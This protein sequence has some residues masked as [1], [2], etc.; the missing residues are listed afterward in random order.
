[1]PTCYR[2]PGRET[3]I[4]C[5]R[6]DKPICPDCMRDAAVGFQCPD[7]VK[8]AARTSRQNRAL[9]GGRRSADPRLT[10]LVLI[11]INVAVWLAVIA[12]GWKNS[13]LIARLALVPKGTCES[14]SSGGYYPTAAGERLCMLG[15]GGDGHWVPG[16]ADGAVWQL[17]TSQFLHVEIWHIAG[18][19]L[20]LWVLGPQ[21]EAILGRT[22]FL[23]LYLLSGLAGSV[24]VLWLSGSGGLTLGASGAI[25]GL[26]GAYAVIAHKVRADLR[27]IATL[28]VVNLF[29]TFAI[30]NI[31]WQGHLGGIVG[32]AIIAAV[33]AYAPRTR[34]TQ[35]QA[36]G[37]AGFFIVLVALIALR[38]AAL[39]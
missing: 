33:I 7:C 5:Q 3:W 24:A 16:V 13:D 30:P 29:I 25:Y 14:L 4:R 22:R 9:Y 27:S 38:I 35:V 36:L 21:L 28:L 39:A 12:T 1:M 17:I 31:S 19:M 18:N 11:G 2:H 10:S 32:G 15:T 20:A 8:E 26:F 34:R 23:V 6:C 37:L